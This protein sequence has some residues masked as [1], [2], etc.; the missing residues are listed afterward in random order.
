MYLYI[1]IYWP[2]IGDGNL[3]I[4]CR[5]FVGGLVIKNLICNAGA[6]GSIPGW[7]ALISHMPHDQNIRT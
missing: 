7:R 2:N 6:K 5:D 4:K 1:Y 3:I